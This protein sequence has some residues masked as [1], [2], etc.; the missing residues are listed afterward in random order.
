MSNYSNFIVNNIEVLK[1]NNTLVNSQEIIDVLQDAFESGTGSDPALLF[2]GLRVSV[3][4]PLNGVNLDE[5]VS[6]SLISQNPTSSIDVNPIFKSRLAPLSTLKNDLEIYFKSIKIKLK[7]KEAVLDP[8]FLFNPP[9]SNSFINSNSIVNNKFSLD[10]DNVNTRIINLNISSSISQNDEDLSNFLT[11]DIILVKN[12]Q[13]DLV[14]NYDDTS[15][16]LDN[17]DINR[18]DEIFDIDSDSIASYLLSDNLFLKIDA[19]DLSVKKSGFKNKSIKKL[20]NEKY[21]LDNSSPLKFEIT[22]EYLQESKIEFD[23]SNTIDFTGTADMHVSVDG[24]ITELSDTTTRNKYLNFKKFTSISSQNNVYDDRFLLHN[25]HIYDLPYDIDDTFKTTKSITKNKVENLIKQKRNTFTQTPFNENRFDHDHNIKISGSQK[26]QDWETA[27]LDDE[28]AEGYDI[29]NQKQIKI[30]LD[31]SS[32]VDLHLMNTKFTFNLPDPNLVFS[33]RDGQSQIP[34]YNEV[35]VN[36]DRQLGTIDSNSFAT[37]QDNLKNTKYFNFVSTPST[38]SSHFMPTAYWDFNNN[39]WDYLE[40]VVLDKDSPLITQQYDLNLAADQGIKSFD[41]FGS[42]N[43]SVLKDLYMSFNNIL[44][45]PKVLSEELYFTEASFL[46]TNDGEYYLSSFLRSKKPILTT[47][48]FRNDAGFLSS[49]SYLSSNKS[50]L[51]QITSSY[52][53]PGGPNWQ[54][55]NDHVLDMSKYITQDFLL[56][57]IIIK[58]KY[59]M[60]AEMPVSK[61]NFADCYRDGVNNSQVDSTGKLVESYDYKDNHQ[62]FISNNIT[63]FL[64]N[65]RK[66]LNLQ[67]KKVEKLKHQSYFLVPT[68]DGGAIQSI[69]NEDGS[70]NLN[71]NP[72]LNENIPYTTS[73]Y[74]AKNISTVN[75]FVIDKAIEL[76]D[77]PTF[78]MEEKSLSRYEKDFNLYTRVYSG[79]INDYVSYLSWFEEQTTLGSHGRNEFD[80]R[81]IPFE[82]LSN[83]VFE[84]NSFNNKIFKNKENGKDFIKRKK[85]CFV[86]LEEFSD[87]TIEQQ[88]NFVDYM[89]YNNFKNIESNIAKTTMADSNYNILQDFQNNNENVQRYNIIAD[90]PQDYNEEVTRELVTYASLLVSSKNE[91]LLI[92]DNILKNID[93]YH[94]IVSNQDK[95]S[96]DV[97]NPT[98]FTIYASLK[99]QKAS[100]Y[101]SESIYEIKS[102]FK[103]NYLGNLKYTAN[104]MEGKTLSG[105]SNSGIFSDRLRN[106]RALEKNR[107]RFKSNSGKIINENYSSDNVILCNYILKP[108]D[109]LIFG[110][111]SYSNG[112][113]MSTVTKLHDKI[114][115]ILIGREVKNKNIN[116]TNSQNDSISKIITGHNRH[117]KG[118]N[119]SIQGNK[120]FFDRIW[121]DY[122][123]FKI[124]DSSLA[125]LNNR[126]IKSYKSETKTNSNVLKLLN[127]KNINNSTVYYKKDTV[128]PSVSNIL[129][130]GYDKN[131]LSDV[132]ASDNLN[133]YKE[134]KTLRKV[135]ISDSINQTE[136]DNILSQNETHSTFN[137]MYSNI[138]NDWH[139]VYIFNDQR[140]ESLLNSSS[141]LSEENS[142]YIDAGDVLSIYYDINSYSIGGNYDLLSETKTSDESKLIRTVLEGDINNNFID[143]YN[144]TINTIKSYLTPS[145]SL[146]NYQEG[147]YIKKFNASQCLNTDLSY[148]SLPHV[149]NG[150][151]D[152]KTGFSNR[153]GSNNLYETISHYHLNIGR[154]NS[155]LTYANFDLDHSEERFGLWEFLDINDLRVTKFN[156]FVESNVLIENIKSTN[157]ADYIE[158]SEASMQYLNIDNLS[159]DF[160]ENNLTKDLE[161]KH[162]SS[163]YFV[164]E[165]TDA[166]TT[167]IITELQT[168]DN[169]EY[170]FESY[171]NKNIAIDL[172]PSV[173]DPS[174][175]GI[176]ILYDSVKLRESVF[177]ENQSTDP[178]HILHRTARIIKKDENKAG[179]VNKIIIPLYF[180]ETKEVD[181]FYIEY[182]LNN[183]NTRSE[184][185]K[186]P[187]YSFDLYQSIT[188]LIEYTG[189]FTGLQN[190]LNYNLN[191][192]IDAIYTSLGIG[193]NWWDHQLFR[194]SIRRKPEFY[195]NLAGNWI[196]HL[197]NGQTVSSQI[198]VSTG[199]GNKYN[200]YNPFVS[201]TGA[202]QIQ[203]NKIFS[204]L[205]SLYGMINWIENIED[206]NIALPG[207]DNPSQFIHNYFRIIDESIWG[208][209]IPPDPLV[210]DPNSSFNVVSQR[211]YP[212]GESKVSIPYNIQELNDLSS[213]PDM[214]HPDM[215][216]KLIWS[217]S[218]YNSPK[219]FYIKLSK[220]KNK[221]DSTSKNTFTIKNINT[222]QLNLEENVLKNKKYFSSFFALNNKRSVIEEKENLNIEN[223]NLEDENFYLNEKVY[224]SNIRFYKNNKY[225][226]SKYKMVYKV[227]LF[228]DLSYAVSSTK[229]ADSSK[230]IKNYVDKNDS[231]FKNIINAAYPN[232]YPYYTIQPYTIENSNYIFKKN[233]HTESCLVYDSTINRYNNMSNLSNEEKSKDGLITPINSSYEKYNNGLYY[234]NNKNEK[235]EKTSQ[236]VKKTLR[237]Y[238]DDLSKNYNEINLQNNV[239]S[240]YAANLDDQE[241][242]RSGLSSPYFEID[243]NDITQID[244][245]VPA[246][247]HFDF[248]TLGDD[249]IVESRNITLDQRL[250]SQLLDYS[251]ID[252]P[253]ESYYRRSIPY[254]YNKIVKNLPTRF[255][256]DYQ[257]ERYSK[258]KN[259]GSPVFVFDNEDV[260][261]GG[262]YYNITELEEKSKIFFYGYSRKSI[263]KYPI[264]KLDRFKYGVENASKES[265]SVYWEQG[266]YGHYADKILGSTNFARTYQN[267]NGSY[268]IDYTVFKKFFN[269]D[270]RIFELS[271]LTTNYSE[272]YNKDIHSRSFAPFYDASS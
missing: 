104:S 120:N 164:L 83:T 236:L 39:K 141:V 9:L 203:N 7:A 84:N 63:F 66:N 230:E 4:F 168:N 13:G 234:Y 163:W 270:D 123:N 21:S 88:T 229:S 8:S 26:R 116:N 73:Y 20:I 194:Y 23:D 138:I 77:P 96:I 262:S 14:F 6:S 226:K 145:S 224:T 133:L 125:N 109:K 87:Q 45:N 49:E 46:K 102:N 67:D 171:Y 186:H 240:R 176:H 213:S 149:T 117:A 122:D 114:E 266:S 185:K 233:K 110:A 264:E 19:K 57:K 18:I 56:E 54:H 139:E 259:A 28:I 187:R 91:G 112:E 152:L 98:E 265:E 249:N 247:E 258:Y 42:K 29:R 181:G 271:P 65:E 136:I 157:Q 43:N 40:G 257:Q 119:F 89:V 221:N 79:V 48:S 190:S 53:F 201:T 200:V 155:L 55:K 70:D 146:L 215:V 86:H 208:S 58:G 243:L 156:S 111:T 95:L 235:L 126:K 143:S 272:T 175:P 225:N 189:S 137:N 195:K 97:V 128:L 241:D 261:I 5:R 115:I 17:L 162:K 214:Y 179:D 166:Q 231:I 223:V 147:S 260:G 222:E 121:N 202:E 228:N 25:T 60:K 93:E 263:Y 27:T 209:T 64:L 159:F 100:D 10:F 210:Q 142:N 148:V 36:I 254:T 153:T 218:L 94:E 113:V 269:I 134:N 183:N 108:E 68:Y 16:T 197:S 205:Y 165:I 76:S 59:T 132:E 170:S 237:I 101:N 38:Y 245:H 182:N 207:N 220:T 250:S 124:Y 198:P 169:N 37:V 184:N 41:L 74:D 140:F 33:D 2:G 50:Y 242:I 47:P 44:S 150:L 227:K 191:K 267:S 92:D 248:S 15:Y 256:Q 238:E 199:Y 160:V 188:G 105:P 212:F 204:N 107:S 90:N 246:N 196:G 127:K 177:G 61:G 30:T 180:W 253:S 135:L 158:I 167:Q 24:P 99:N 151:P 1:K 161:K 232:F 22:G 62:G 31:F 12:Y 35:R 34:G 32:N 251:G 106:E 268:F 255:S 52:N 69:K 154:S 11:F 144:F 81:I 51:T 118:E 129:L 130:N 192:R 103:T 173:E 71:N 217:Q 239:Y 172:T 85:N 219:K 131:L 75:T 178:I 216:G 206:L 193:E 252:M 80:A 78:D 72:G 244:N 211:V 174:N 3:Y 82:V